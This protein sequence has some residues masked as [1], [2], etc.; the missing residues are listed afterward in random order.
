MRKRNNLWKLINVWL[1]W[2]IMTTLLVYRTAYS[3]ACPEDKIT[4]L[5]IEIGLF[6]F[7]YKFWCEEYASL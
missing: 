1:F 3:N 2:M 6:M 4:W 7:S 5:L